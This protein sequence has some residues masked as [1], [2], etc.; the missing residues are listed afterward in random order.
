MFYFQKLSIPITENIILVKL[1]SELKQ[2][3][4]RRVNF[5]FYED[6][7]QNENSSKTLLNKRYLEVKLDKMP[8]GTIPSSI[9]R[10]PVEF[11][12]LQSPY[13]YFKEPSIAS[14]EYGYEGLEARVTRSVFDEIY[15]PLE[16]PT[17]NSAEDQLTCFKIPQRDTSC[18]H[19]DRNSLIQDY[20]NERSQNDPYFNG[21]FTTKNNNDSY[22][23]KHSNY[24]DVSS[25]DPN[26]NESYKLWRKVQS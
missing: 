13:K 10:Y 6:D 19:K 12:D 23:I 22:M 26:W 1:L 16:L 9:R 11:T 25:L 20:V 14:L 15:K 4:R 3:N 24:K 8:R 7:K 17:L 2:D 21:I 5:A 18:C